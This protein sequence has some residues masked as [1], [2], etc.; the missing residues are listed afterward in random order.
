MSTK[1]AAKLSATSITI[2]RVEGL[3]SECKS[4]TF[5][6]PSAWKD[7]TRWLSSQSHT[8]PICGSHTVEFKVLFEDGAAY[9]G[10]LECEHFTN[11]GAGADYDI[12]NHMVKY[13]GF[14]AGT[15]KPAHMSESQYERAIGRLP[16]VREKAQMWLAGYQIGA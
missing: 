10:Q 13:L 12:A 14:M 1:T 11:N 2:T 15:R 16:G 9:S 7:A 3:D 5:S 8:F 6:G 4:E